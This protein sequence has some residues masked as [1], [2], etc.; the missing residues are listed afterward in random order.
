MKEE[1]RDGHSVVGRA[2]KGKGGR[3]ERDGG[4]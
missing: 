1:S 4:T 2:E 3:E